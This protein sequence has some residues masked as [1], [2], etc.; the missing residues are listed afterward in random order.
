MRCYA[1]DTILIMLSSS[2]DVLHRHAIIMICDRLRCLRT[3]QRH[4]R[5][6]RPFNMTDES[7]C[8]G[9]NLHPIKSVVACPPADCQWL[10]LDL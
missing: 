5:H 3:R 7:L 9:D 2:C 4:D 1:S 6:A 8:I 10:G